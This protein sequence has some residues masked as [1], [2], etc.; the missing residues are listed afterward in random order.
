[1]RHKVKAIHFVGIGG[2]GMSGIAEVFANL[3]YTVSGS[4]LSENPAVRRLRQMGIRIHLGHAAENVAGADAVVVSTAVKGLAEVEMFQ[5]FGNTFDM[6]T[7]MC[8]EQ[9]HIRRGSGYPPFPVRMSIFQDRHS[10]RDPL[11]PFRMAGA[12]IFQA[13]WVVKNRHRGCK[14]RISEAFRNNGVTSRLSC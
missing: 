6:R 5:R 3:G 8:A 11:R 4:D 14:I 12:G 7:R 10:T 2:S 1:M 13:A 9:R